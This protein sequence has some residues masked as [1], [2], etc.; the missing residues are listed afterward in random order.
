MKKIFLVPGLFLSTAS[1]FC[2]TVFFTSPATFNKDQ[3]SPFYASLSLQGN[4]VLYNAPDYKLYA[5]AKDSGQLAWS[6]DLQY[7]S[8]LAPFLIGD[9][10]LWANSKNGVVQLR[11]STGFLQ[12]D[13]FPFYTIESQPHNKNGLVYGTGIYD[14]GCLFAYDPVKDSLLWYRF[15]A[16]GIS[17][18][19]YY[20]SDRIIANAE[21]DNWLELS[22]SGKLKDAAC[23]TIAVNFPSELPCAKTIEALHPE[24]KAMDKKVARKIRAG[25]H[26]NPYIVHG[27]QQTFVI[28]N[29]IFYVLDKKQKQ[30]CAVHLDSL[31][32]QDDERGGSGDA[33][34]LQHSN[35]SVWVLFREQLLVY[36]WKQKRSIKTI[37]LQKWSPHQVALQ[38]KKLWLISRKDGR[39]YGITL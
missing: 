28:N 1:T 39:L 36:N 2:Q 3:L 11:L 25:E 24:A 14:G 20:Q 15:L 18:T 23:D 16:H 8:N 35:D 34:V 32:I 4:Y 30:L 29:S 13:K 5:Y 31:L 6:F 27:S 33:A 17:V 19:P 37:D 21:G 7:K 9:S 22:Y 12:K 10:S 38:E 26:D